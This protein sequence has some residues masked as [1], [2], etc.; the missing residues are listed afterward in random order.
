GVAKNLAEGIGGVVVGAALMVFASQWFKR[1]QQHRLASER[2]AAETARAD[3][4]TADAEPTTSPG[5]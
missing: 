3:R 5:S 2:A 4:P 1:R